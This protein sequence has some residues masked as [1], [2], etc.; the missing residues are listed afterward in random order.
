MT[1][2]LSHVRNFAA[3]A[4]ISR[5]AGWLPVHPR[6]A[7]QMEESGGHDPQTFRSLPASNGCR[8]AGPVHSP[9]R[10]AAVSIRNRLRGPTRFQRVAAPGRFTI[11]RI[12]G[13]ELVSIRSAC[14][15]SR[16]QG[17]ADPRSVSSPELA[18][19]SGLE[20]LTPGLG[21]RCSIQ[22]S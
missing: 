20:P 10:M 1:T 16:F 8:R 15:P 19:S 6:S 18:A 13:E 3:A 11:H 22:L 7:T 2:S 4:C 21:N 14:A 17:G 5:G 12:G 9:W